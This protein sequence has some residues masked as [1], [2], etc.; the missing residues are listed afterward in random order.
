MAITVNATASSNGMPSAPLRAVQVDVDLDNSYPAG[1]YAIAALAGKTI[2]TSEYVPH[3]DASELRWFRLE[4]PSA[5][6]V[7]LVAYDT[8]DGAPSTE[9]TAAD[10]MTGHTGLVVNGLAE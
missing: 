4:S 1:G 8:A 2:V 6:V 9:T 5:G 3:Y 10:D 7:N